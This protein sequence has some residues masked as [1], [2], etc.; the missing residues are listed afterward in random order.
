M[1]LEN[2]VLKRSGKTLIKGGNLPLQPGKV[3][4]F[5][6][7]S[8]GGKSTLLYGLAD[9]DRH[10]VL[11]SDQGEQP[12]SRLRVGVVPQ[13][14]AVFEDFG[15]ARKNLS[16]A[17]DHLPRGER[18]EGQRA[19]KWARD[20]LGI[21]GTWRFPLSGGQRQRVAIARALVGNARVLLF[22][23]PTSG[24]DPASRAEAIKVVGEAARTGVSVLVVTHDLEWNHPEAADTIVL[25]KNRILETRGPG[26]DLAPSFFLRSPVDAEEDQPPPL[27]ER[28]MAQWGRTLWWFGSVPAQIALGLR[29]EEKVKPGWLALFLRHFGGMVWGVSSLIYLAVAGILVGFSSLYFSVGALEPSPHLQT[30]LVPELLSGSGFGLYR[31]IIPLLAA[32]LVAAKCGS[33]L[34][35]DIGNRA[36]GGQIGVMRTM[37]TNPETYLLLPALIGFGIGL[38][39]L[40]LLAFAMASTGSLMGYLLTFPQET[41]FSWRSGF[42]RLLW[43][44]GGFLPAG[45]LWN[46]TKLSLSGMGVAMIAYYCGSLPK[47]SNTD[48]GQDI[49]RATVWGS[50]WCL[51]VF[52]LFA[53]VEF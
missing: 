51:I 38:P 26:E 12:L 8:G 13:Q 22:D 47:T 14:S 36:Y 3:T 27:W 21:D 6:G 19:M 41:V 50:L 34:A 24:L 45:T 16:F 33:A 17:Y 37:G 15:E 40:H 18:E 32:L 53:L 49:S 23:E 7:P 20:S 35:A 29:G 25:L 10:V 4:V 5:F 31:V 52:T 9:L 11:R 42:F 2:I 46:F 30:I 44:E 1:I 48:V 43:A 28:K 39:L